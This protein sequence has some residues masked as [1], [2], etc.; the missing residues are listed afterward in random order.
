MRF[1]LVCK[2]FKD[3]LGYFQTPVDV[4]LLTRLEETKRGVSWLITA[5]ALLSRLIQYSSFR[6]AQDWFRLG[7]W[8]VESVQCISFRKQLMI[9]PHC[10]QHQF[11]TILLFYLAAPAHHGCIACGE[12][13]NLPKNH[14]GKY[15]YSLSWMLRHW[16]ESLVNYARIKR[17]QLLIAEEEDISSLPSKK[18][19]RKL[20]KSSPI[21]VCLRKVKSHLLT[22][23]AHKI[24]LL[25]G[26]GI[27]LKNWPEMY[28]EYFIEKICVTSGF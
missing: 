7:W 24:T 17:H 13:L 9:F 4:K 3:Y 11:P 23:S 5:A 28:V 12:L 20:T 6:A 21:Q 1:C 18:S 19:V 25:Y 14:Y 22:N 26:R 2:N 15:R 10:S 16:Y 8:W 27:S